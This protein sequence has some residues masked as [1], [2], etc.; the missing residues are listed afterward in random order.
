MGVG[1]VRIDVES[2]FELRPCVLFSAQ[3]QKR[4]AQVIVGIGETGIHAN[5][6]L[7]SGDGE[8]DP[9][10]LMK[11]GGIGKDLRSTRGAAQSVRPASCFAIS[12]QA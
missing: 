5:R 11:L 2:T 6:L 12:R 9:A 1:I 8:V 7:V 3:L 10:C 4:N